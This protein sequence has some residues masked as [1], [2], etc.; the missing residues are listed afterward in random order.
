MV[1]RKRDQVPKGLGK[2]GGERERVEGG[3]GGGGRGQGSGVKVGVIEN[4]NKQYGA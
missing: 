4:V 1:G 3:G 2:E